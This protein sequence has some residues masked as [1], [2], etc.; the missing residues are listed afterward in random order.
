MVNTNQTPSVKEEISNAIT[1]GLG[2]LLAIAALVLLVIFSIVRGTV[3]DV[4]SFS[5]FGGTLVTLYLASTLYH[6]I[7]H[8][9]TKH[10]LRKVD[11]M[12]IFLLIAGTYTPFCLTLRGWIGW[13]M[14]GIIWTCAILGV[15]LKAFY[16]G[17]HETLSTILYVVMG[18]FGMLACKPLYDTIPFSS[19]LFLIAGGLFY[20][21]GTFFFVRDSK[22]YY[23]SVWH[24]FVVAGSA[25]HFFSV[26]ALLR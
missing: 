20:T 12:S 18:W 21:A 17:Q 10:F 9:K 1:H 25:A 19:F 6:S 2:A 3:W 13:A 11:H 7:T 16:T 22:R 26:V 24:I 4:V 8:Q 15:V 5:I 14:L 23:H